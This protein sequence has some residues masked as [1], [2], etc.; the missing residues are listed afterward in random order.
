MAFSSMSIVKEL[1]MKFSEDTGLTSNKPQRRYL[2]TDGFAVCNFLG[3]YQVSNESNY[4]D[5]AIQLVDQVHRILGKH[6]EDDER[7]GWLGS[8]DHPTEKGLRIGKPLNERKPHE[9]FNPN[10]EWE[11]DGQYFHYLTKWMHSLIRVYQVVKEEKYLTWAVDLAEASTVFISNNRMF[12]K[13]S[14]D[15]SYPLVPSMGQHDP[16]DGYITFKEIQ[17]FTDV[18]L[19]VALTKLEK[20]IP[21]INL[22]TNDPLGIGGLLF[23]AYRLEQMNIESERKQVLINAAQKGLEYCRLSH[24]LAFRELGLAIGL[25]AAKKMSVLEDYWSL[26]DEINN[27][28]LQNSNWTEHVDINRVMLATSVT[29]DSFLSIS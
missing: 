27:Y 19:G 7:S 11:R 20:L 23:D 2:W 18:D 1:M 22:V 26:I 15:L 5:L 29:P 10:L 17:T 16:V 24:I 28:W 13:M 4:K 6:R 21:Q 25:Q 8:K 9:P 12:W 3:F 14:I